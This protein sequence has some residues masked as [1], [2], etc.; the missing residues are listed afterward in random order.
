MRSIRT[1]VA[2][3]VRRAGTSLLV[4]TLLLAGAA[5]ASAAVSLELV[6]NGFLAPVGVTNAGD[7]RLFVVERAGRIRVLAPAGSGWTNGVTFLDLRDKVRTGGEEG[8]LGLAFHPDYATNRRFYVYYTNTAGNGVVAEYRRRVNDP[9]RAAPKSAR[10]VLRL[11]QPASTHNGGWIGFSGQNLLIALGDGSVNAQDAQDL[12]MLRGKILRI[13]PL[14]PDGPGPRRY[15]IPA[16]NPYVGIAGR[17]EVWLYG[18]R[19]PWRASVDPETGDLWIGD[20]GQ[21][22]REEVTRVP[23][24]PTVRDLGWP[25]VEGAH[26][27]LDN[28]LAG[29]ASQDLCTT[30]CGFLP[31][32]EIPHPGACS[33]IGGHVS[34]REGAA[35]NGRYVFAD[36][37]LQ[38]VWDV[39]A[40]RTLGPLPDGSSV[41]V[42]VVSFGTGA[43]GRIYAVN[44]W[45]SGAGSVWYVTG[46]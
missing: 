42:S 33:V 35:L 23:A 31:I 29:C 20:V 24:A 43:D 30:D 13:D 19:N 2:C 3:S 26:D 7:E 34:R 16:G 38:T 40:T 39:P 37:C 36:L 6:A 1:A 21:D 45:G 12:T 17:D 28:W 11:G 8:L 32:A 5:P 25:R 15:A 14:D 10:T 9:Q 44:G 4:L 41:G 18:L 27:A 22:C 46:S